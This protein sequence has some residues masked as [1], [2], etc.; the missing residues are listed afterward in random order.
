MKKKK[1]V[2][3]LQVYFDDANWE[4]IEII[5]KEVGIKTK[6]QAVR[7]AVKFYADYL[8]NRQKVV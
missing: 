7:S 1:S 6:S 5:K 2:P 4:H 8:K 3:Y